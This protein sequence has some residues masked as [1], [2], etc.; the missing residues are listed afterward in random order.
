MSERRYLMI[1]GDCH[2]GPPLPAFRDYFESDARD[3]FD[4][5]CKKALRILGDWESKQGKDVI[6]PPWRFRQRM[7][8]HPQKFKDVVFEL[9]LMW[10]QK[11]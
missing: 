2:A 7:N 8:L 6:M 1:S 3:E 11:N 5:Y 4:A 10:L 9:E